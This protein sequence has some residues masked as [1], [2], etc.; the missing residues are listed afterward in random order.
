MEAGP[1]GGEGL[2]RTA[3]NGDESRSWSQ[4]DLLVLPMWDHTHTHTEPERSQG[5]RSSGCQP[6]LWR[7][8]WEDWS[9]HSLG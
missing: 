8:P 3:G 2:A 6:V 7:G 5:G 1:G 9:C 4:Q